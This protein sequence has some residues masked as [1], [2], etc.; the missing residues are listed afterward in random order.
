MSE[1]PKPKFNIG[2]NACI[3]DY[4]SQNNTPIVCTDCNGTGHHKKSS[5]IICDNCGG[6]GKLRQ[7]HRQYKT[8]EL[9]TVGG[10]FFEEHNHTFQYCLY[11]VG[12]R[13]GYWELIHA[14]YDESRVFSTVEE[15][16]KE[17]DRLN[18]EKLNY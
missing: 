17:C 18:S 13:G 8:G 16:Q 5:V 1:F 10:V 15:A 4:E 2:D 3:I 9:L 11:D 12:M 6:I 7:Y 14:R